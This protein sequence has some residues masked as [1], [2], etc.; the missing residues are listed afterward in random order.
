[1]ALFLAGT[2]PSWLSWAPFLAGTTSLGGSQWFSFWQAQPLSG[3]HRFPIWLGAALY[4]APIG[5]LS[6]SHWLPPRLV[7]A[8]YLAPIGSLFGLARALM[9]LAL[10]PYL[11]RSGSLCVS[12]Q[13]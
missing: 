2:A 8:L 13:L 1:M 5:S 6:V 3:S 4:L 10:A 12:L 11:A 7:L 9:R